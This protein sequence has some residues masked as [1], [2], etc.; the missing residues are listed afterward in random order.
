MTNETLVEIDNLVYL[1]R[2]P[3]TLL[4]EEIEKVITAQNESLIEPMNSLDK[5]EE[6]ETLQFN[7]QLIELIDSLDDDKKQQ[8]VEILSNSLYQLQKSYSA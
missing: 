6:L 1:A 2:E 4:T 7:K 5:E 8:L 3:D